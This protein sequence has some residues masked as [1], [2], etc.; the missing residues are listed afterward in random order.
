MLRLLW[1]TYESI[2]TVGNLAGHNISLYGSKYHGYKNKIFSLEKLF[3]VQKNCSFKK[4]KIKV[5]EQVMA[6]FQFELVCYLHVNVN[7]DVGYFL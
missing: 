7:N 4:G 3:F 1:L 2:I 5:F 6:G